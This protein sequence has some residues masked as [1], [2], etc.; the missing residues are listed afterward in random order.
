MEERVK[1]AEVDIGVDKLLKKSGE[2]KKRI[3]EL[4]QENKQLSKETSN[5]TKATSEQLEQFTRNDVEL[6]NLRK[7][8]SNNTKVLNA[9]INIQNQDIRTKQEARDANS[10]LIAIANQLDA[11]NEDQAKLLKKVN[12]EIDRNT[13]FIKQNA[14]EYERNKINIGNYKES[15]KQALQETSIFGQY[16]QDLKNIF[17]SFSPVW[18]T[19]KNDFK[20]GAVQIRNSAKA[21]EGLTLAQRAQQAA[22]LAGAGA[23]KIFR[24]AM[25]ATGIGA[26]VVIIGSLVSYLAST[27]EGIDK[28]NRV[29]TPLKEVFSSLLGVVQ[30]LG[31]E[32]FQALSNPKKLITDLGNLIKENLVN[33]FTALGKI[34]DSFLEGDWAGVRDGVL[35]A[36][37]GVENLTGK[38]KNLGKQTGDFFDQAWKR[39]QQI[40]TI[41][42]NLNKSEAEYITNQAKL[43][44]EFEQQ[45]KLSEDINKPISEREAAAQRAIQAQEEI[46]KGTVDRLNLEAKL[47]EFKQQAND[48]SDQEK[49]DLARKLAEIDKALEEEAAKT[50]EAQNKLNAIR[51]EGAQK[52]QEIANQAIQ[53]TVEKLE[54]EISLYEEQQRLKV[55]TDQDQLSHLETLSE[56]E[57]N[58]LNVK[59]RNKL[60]SQTEYET[61]SLKLENDI[62]EK[63]AE[64][65]E[66]ELER[67]K[68]FEDRKKALEDQIYEQKLQTDQEREQF[69]LEKEFE[70]READIEKTIE[71]AE[72][73]KEL[74]ALLE[75]EKAIRLNEVKDKYA[76]EQ[77]EKDRQRAEQ[78][79]QMRQEIANAQ[80]NI[81]QGLSGLLSAV[82]G[83]NEEL[84]I[85]SLLLEK[86]VAASRVILQTQIANAKALAASPLTFG[87]PFVGYNYVQMGLSLATIAAQSVAGISKIK[88]QSEG[89]RRTPRAEKGIALDITGKRHSQGGETFYDSQGNAV[90]E[91][92]AGEKMVILKREASRELDTLS[93]LNQKHGG[94]SLSKPVTYANNGGAVVR[95][96][97]LGTNVKLP[98]KLIDYDLLAAKMASANMA[99]PNPIVDVKDVSAE[100]YRIHQVE[101][102]ADL[103]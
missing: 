14:S 83:E 61:E 19:V 88:K 1:I 41:Q 27:Q 95:R 75:E 15:V 89:S 55:K 76:Q 73:R 67:I 102:G 35:Q 84:Q 18:N 4:A 26:F 38:V 2:A 40:E 98:K 9:Y 54:Q 62:A 82:A 11:T 36:G 17:V 24:A 96:S 85:A 103:S 57:Q 21:T 101:T 43:R 13:D 6:K 94:V 58:I 74:L 47:L 12:A 93:F 51:K 22:T 48:T 33:R 79:L 87:Q 91:A 81:A 90:V 37:T 5:L 60:I 69:K 25:I 68:D 28:V 100:Q 30:N 34:V 99:L 39:G 65:A 20:E 71:D 80:A 49:A 7:Q 42:Q 70:K 23:W 10:K 78:E 50:T 45:K 56:K 46:R 52:Q 29:L 92:E 31:K 16:S 77:L 8:Y 32:L 66:N 44:K 3:A 86:G 59:L 63:K 97:G 53:N 72:Q 64:I